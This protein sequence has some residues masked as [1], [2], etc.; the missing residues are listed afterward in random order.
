[1]GTG[2]VIKRRLLWYGAGAVAVW[3]LALGIWGGWDVADPVASVVGA[4]AGVAALAYALVAPLDTEHMA[5]RLAR[6]V[7]R[8]EQDEYV[9]WLDGSVGGRI[10]LAYT[11]RVHGQV[12]G[13]PAEGRLSDLTA[14]HGRLSPPRMVITGGDGADDA[15][16]G[17]S[18]AALSMVLDLARDR[19]AGQ[20]VP[21]RMAATSWTGQELE[22]WLAGHLTTAFGVGGAL[23]RRLVEARLVLPVVDGL[24]E[25]DPPGAAPY[26]SRAAQLLRLLNGWQHGTQPAAV[27]V[28]CRRGFYDGLMRV[29]A[30]L[31][32]A[33]VV[34]LAP[35]DGEQGRAFLRR[36]V[37]DTE[38][39]LRRWQPVLDALATGPR[40][41]HV[42]PAPAVVRLRRVL[43]TPWR[44]SLATAVY[45]E[46]SAEGHYLRDP[47]TLLRLAESG[48]LHRHLLDLYVPALLATRGDGTVPPEG[49]ARRWLAVLA[50]YLDDNRN[51][52]Q[53]EGRTLSATDLV[54]PELWPLVGAEPT[55]RAIRWAGLAWAGALELVVVVRAAVM[56]SWDQLGFS[57]LPLFTLLFA[58]GADLWE[59]D[60]RMV[61]R[62]G[63]FVLG[64]ALGFAPPM[65]IALSV[66]TTGSP[67]DWVMG[68]AAFGLMAGGAMGISVVPDERRHGPHSLVRGDTIT[69]AL[70]MADLVA[71]AALLGY[72][73]A[74]WRGLSGV[75]LPIAVF[76][77]LLFHTMTFRYL[78][79]LVLARRILP[80]RL[81]R[82]LRA[83][84][85]AGILR[86]SGAAYQ[87]RHLELQDHL[88]GRQDRPGG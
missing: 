54:L 14:L 21:L 72:V 81:G 32:A 41:D 88:A 65:L 71:L 8:R 36:S 34:R 5:D 58:F 64:C 70:F 67:T 20:A 40:E 45:Q 60:D 12:D 63:R 6:E 26:S 73:I 86:T 30:H 68:S 38:A 77:A 59:G 55:R 7:V 87:F 1:M 79:F 24:D 4:L 76:G 57:M 9:R 13:A 27:L 83:C 25:L 17:K 75:F 22:A 48:T 29:E 11:V 49:P 23:A 84:H 66:P 39:G 37:A 53:A 78:V 15:G 50:S 69:W 47:A 2:H 52:R 10:D 16:T 80:W 18:L 35:V 3:L 31:R 46:R 43:A 74:G 61:L 62:P 33:A 42:T 82:F 44:L 51:G 85:R 19:E 28:T 56:D